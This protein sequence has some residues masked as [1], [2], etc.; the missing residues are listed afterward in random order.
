MILEYIATKVY[1]SA[2]FRDGRF[3]YLC[4]EANSYSTDAISNMETF[5]PDNWRIL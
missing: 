5:L 1:P 3:A 4:S 2:L